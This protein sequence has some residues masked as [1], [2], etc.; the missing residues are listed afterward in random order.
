MS[1]FDFG[2]IDPTTKSGTAL[3]SDLNS[4][5]TALNSCHSGSTRPTYAI[6]KTIWVNDAT[7]PWVVYMYDGA[8]DIQ[9]GTI[10]ATTNVFTPN[11]VDLFIHAATD[12][13]VPIGTDELIIYDSVSAS[14]K[15]VTIDNL[16]KVASQPLSIYQQF[17]GL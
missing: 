6:A 1:Q 15:K 14:G 12:K 11:G 2:T 16:R 5:R 9:I 10:N 17:Q 7:T 13:P 4:F 3:A 8:D